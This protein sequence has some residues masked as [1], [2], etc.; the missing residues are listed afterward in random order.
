[1]QAKRIDTLRIDT[2]ASNAGAI[3]IMGSAT[4]SVVIPSYNMDWCVGRAIR[5]CQ[6]QTAA[7]REIIVVDDCS[8]DNTEAIIR[9]LMVADQRIK[10]YRPA[11]NG[12]PLAALSLGAERAQADWIAFLDADDEL[13]PNSIECRITKAANYQRSTGVKPQLIYG[14]LVN[15]RFADM[16]GYVFPYLCREL[17]LCQTST[18]MLGAESIPHFP[19]STNG[20]N[21]DDEI[22]LAVG[23]LFHVLHWWVGCCRLLRPL[24]RNEAEQQSAEDFQWRP[25]SGARASSRYPKPTRIRAP[26][27]MAPPHRQ[28]IPQLSDNDRFG[29]N[30]TFVGGAS[31]SAATLQEGADDPLSRAQI[32]SQAALRY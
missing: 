28:N 27:A 11:A 20:Y 32:F 4:T 31:V 21:T 10:Y 17:C 26:H 7:L 12:G 6:N 15:Y 29:T 19:K 14:D 3:H 18:I 9:D 16:K 25:R 5:S 1:M 30:T 24:K 23:K 22:V 8:S 13:T 2:A